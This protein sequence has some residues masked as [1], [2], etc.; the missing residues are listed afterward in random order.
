VYLNT[1]KQLDYDIARG[2]WIADYADPANLLETFQTGNGKHRGGYSNAEYDALLTQ[3]Q[4]EPDPKNGSDSSKGRS[5]VID[6]TALRAGLSLHEHLLKV[7][8]LKGFTP[9]ILGMIP[10]KS[11]Y[12]G[13]DGRRNGTIR[14]RKCVEQGKVHL[15]AFF[16]PLHLQ[17]LANG[18]G[19]LEKVVEWLVF[20]GRWRRSIVFR[21][22]DSNLPTLSP[23]VIPAKVGIQRWA[24][25]KTKGKTQRKR[26]I[27]QNVPDLG[28]RLR[29]NDGKWN[30]VQT[31]M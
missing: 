15:R 29:G 12:F 24:N 2:C 25:G 9:N 5:V 20:R 30:G 14:R 23:P 8:E 22:C 26:T 10:Y 17:R 27:N 31:G 11:L 4:N 18:I 19:A 7:P 6:G 28:S 13:A 3:A 1:V 16:F 21:S